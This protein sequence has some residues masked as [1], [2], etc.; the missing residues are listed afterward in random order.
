[1]AGDPATVRRPHAAGRVMT[2]ILDD[3][4]ARRLAGQPLTAADAEALAAS[5]DIVTLGMIADELRR[6]RHGRR[7][8]FVRVADVDLPLEAE[9]PVAWP[10]SAGEVR[11]RGP[12]PGIESATAAVSLVI[13]AAGDVP[14]TAFSLA[15]PRIGRG[16]FRTP[17]RL[18]R[19]SARCGAG[20]DCS[21]HPSIGSPRPRRRSAAAAAAAL[22]VARLVARDSGERGTSRSRAPRHGARRVGRGCARV[23]AAARDARR[24]RRRGTPT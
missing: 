8:T 14:V 3:I 5:Y 22:P 2:A 9:E 12:F 19:R 21:R 7:T 6:A 24:S 11:I 15:G 1:M 18:A 4:A 23:R 16:G 17:G 10:P 13:A 20:R